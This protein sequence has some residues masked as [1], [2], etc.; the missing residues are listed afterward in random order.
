MILNKSNPKQ[1]KSVVR[2][3]IRSWHHYVS[4]LQHHSINKCQQFCVFSVKTSVNFDGTD[5]DSTE[6]LVLGPNAYN[7]RMNF[8]L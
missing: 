6:G 5:A 2:R 8:E 3:H 7:R 4:T 1:K